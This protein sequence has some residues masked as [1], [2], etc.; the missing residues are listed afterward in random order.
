MEIIW[1]REIFIRA[2]LFNNILC[3][4]RIEVELIFCF[5]TTWILLS[6]DMLSMGWVASKTCDPWMKGKI[7]NW[8]A[9][10]HCKI[11]Q[12]WF[13]TNL[14]GFTCWGCYECIL[15]SLLQN[16]KRAI[17]SNT[18]PSTKHICENKETKKRKRKLKN[19][20][21]KK[22][23]QKNPNYGYSWCWKYLRNVFKKMK[24]TRTQT[25]VQKKGPKHELGF[26]NSNRATFGTKSS[27]TLLPKRKGTNPSSSSGVFCGP[28]LE[29]GFYMPW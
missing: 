25:W 21:K 29:L 26:F 27:S 3:L 2:F 1:Q 23:Q 19:E 17:K 7:N 14:H 5:W 6:K 15:H 20:F 24:K 22:E 11:T 8:Q 9:N 16:K 13:N 18:K 4:L 28:K 12:G 10:L